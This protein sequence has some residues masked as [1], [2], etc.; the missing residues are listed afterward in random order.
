MKRKGTVDYRI[1]AFKK[2]FNENLDLLIQIRDRGEDIVF[3][4]I[5]VPC[6]LRNLQCVHD[7]QLHWRN[8]ILESEKDNGGNKHGNT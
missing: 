4:N 6:I 5:H 2:E 8:C 7:A 3:Q 1:E